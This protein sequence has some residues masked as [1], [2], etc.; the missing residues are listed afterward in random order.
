MLDDADVEGVIV[1]GD[2]AIGLPVLGNIKGIDDPVLAMLNDVRFA[3]FDLAEFGKSLR[4][5]YIKGMIV[6]SDTSKGFRRQNDAGNELQTHVP[7][8]LY[9]ASIVYIFCSTEKF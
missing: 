1:F 2:F 7:S 9:D 6:A 5:Q 3:M 4:N 8:S